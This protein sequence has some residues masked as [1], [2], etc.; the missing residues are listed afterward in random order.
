MHGTRFKKS[1]RTL[2]TSLSG[3]FSPYNK[4]NKKLD[5]PD[6]WENESTIVEYKRLMIKKN[7]KRN[8][9][10]QG[11]ANLEDLRN[12]FNSPQPSFS[13]NPQ[14]TI[15]EIESLLTKA[16]KLMSKLENKCK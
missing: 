4:T 14:E 7:L 1:R 12:F 5:K 13:V 16:S 10:K 11:I 8:D 6:D 15:Q 2:S 9:H 3:Y